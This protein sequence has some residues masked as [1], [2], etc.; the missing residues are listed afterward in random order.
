MDK[1]DVADVLL[2]ITILSLAKLQEITGKTKDEIFLMI[3]EE[4][5]RSD[6]LMKKLRPVE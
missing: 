3:A 2:N 5:E 6:E 1:Y 4:E